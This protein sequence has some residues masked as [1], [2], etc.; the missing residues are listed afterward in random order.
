MLCP[1]HV[2]R[3]DNKVLRDSEKK[4]FKLTQNFGDFETGSGSL[5]NFFIP[6]GQILPGQSDLGGGVY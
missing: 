3:N 6:R 2:I 1:C 5:F 4:N